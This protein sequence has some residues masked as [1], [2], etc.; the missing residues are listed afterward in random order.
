M[1]WCLLRNRKR[2]QTTNNFSLACLNLT[3]K[4]RNLLESVHILQIKNNHPPPWIHAPSQP[5]GNWTQSHQVLVRC[6]D[7][8]GASYSRG[9][10]EK[11]LHGKQGYF[12]SSSSSSSRI[13]FCS[14]IVGK[15]FEQW[16]NST[17]C[18]WKNQ[19]WVGTKLEP[20]YIYK[21]T[22]ISI[23]LWYQRIN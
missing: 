4:A 11:G 8:K 18:R 16:Q 6:M 1:F 23:N 13:G 9:G 22:N 3:W 20:G 7:G 5:F 17:Y 2:Q 21:T 15:Y 10:G 12:Q 14:F 19:C